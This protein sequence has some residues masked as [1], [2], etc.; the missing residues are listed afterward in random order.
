MVYV[1][2][3]HSSS[4]KCTRFFV[5]PHLFC[6]L[7][8]QKPR[9]NTYF[10]NMHQ[11]ISK[12]LIEI[13][14]N[15]GII[16]KSYGTNINCNKLRINNSVSFNGIYLFFCV[17]SSNLCVNVL[18]SAVSFS[19]SF[20]WPWI[21]SSNSLT[22]ETKTIFNE[23]LHKFGYSPKTFTYYTAKTRLAHNR[24]SIIGQKKWISAN[25]QEIVIPIL[26]S[27]MSGQFLNCLVQ[28]I[29]QQLC[30]TVQPPIIR[31]TFELSVD[32][33][34]T[35]LFSKCRAESITHCNYIGIPWSKIPRKSYEKV[36]YGTHLWFDRIK[37]CKTNAWS[38]EKSLPR[39]FGSLNLMKEWT[40]FFF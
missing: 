24:N 37:H 36:Y 15:N 39:H 1:L 9:I 16:S 5:Y 21:I 13:K 20:L 18:H 35:G 28:N 30:K 19:M 34:R 10:I 11:K 27:L 29:S 8:I 31:D 17:A 23:I 25:F 32:A 4:A 14:Q 26:P 22:V 2:A 33:E 40:F 3:S 7:A 12:P 6:A 38:I